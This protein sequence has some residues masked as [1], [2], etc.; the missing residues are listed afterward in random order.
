MNLLLCVLTSLTSLI[1]GVGSNSAKLM[2]I[3]CCFSGEEF[4]ICSITSELQENMM[5]EV[6]FADVL[7]EK[8]MLRAAVC[9]NLNS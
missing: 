9:E 7:T 3:S 6:G 1:F 2:S 8:T 4:Y 5:V